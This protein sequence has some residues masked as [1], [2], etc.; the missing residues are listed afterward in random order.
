MNDYVPC[1][2]PSRRCTSNL[3]TLYLLACQVR[4]I[5]RGWSLCRCVRCGVFPALL[6]SIVLILHERSGLVM[7]QMVLGRVTV[8]QCEC[9][10]RKESG[11]LIYVA[12]LVKMS[13]LPFYVNKITNCES[14]IFNYI[15]KFCSKHVHS[16]LWQQYL[17]AS[18]A[19]TYFMSQVKCQQRQFTT[20]CHNNLHQVIYY[21]YYLL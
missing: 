2:V 13:K 16:S 18:S 17:R 7:F 8:G 3:C 11:R 19:V 14:V 21:Y 15:V 1:I 4:V 6:N 20:T 12:T 9:N 5:A 10:V